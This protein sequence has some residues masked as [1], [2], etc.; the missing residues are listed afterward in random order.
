MQITHLFIADSLWIALV[1][2]TAEEMAFG[3]QRVAGV[4]EGSFSSRRPG[5]SPPVSSI[6]GGTLP[7]TS[8]T[9]QLRH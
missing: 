4:R 6:R 3:G 8:S 5:A 7:E 9:G 2:L 1:L